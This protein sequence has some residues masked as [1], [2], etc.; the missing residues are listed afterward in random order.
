MIFKNLTMNDDPNWKINELKYS[1]DAM[2]DIV[3]NAY[4]GMVL[5]D[6]DARIL[7][8]CY[9]KL[10]GIKEEDA[11]GKHVD[12]VIENTRLHVVVK[13]GQ[14]ELC[15][16]QRIQG[17]DM[18]ANRIPIKQ[19]GEVI[20]AIGTVL[21]RNIDEIRSM[22]KRLEMLEKTVNKYKNEISKMYS[23]RYTF[24]SIIT[25]NKKM[26]ELKEIA[27]KAAGTDSTVLI[28]GDSGTGKEF[29]AHAIHN[30]SSRKYA[31]FVQI[32]CAAIPHELLESELFGYEGGAFTGAKKEGKIGKLEL[33]N[34]GTILL[35][36]VASMPYS[37]QAKLL[38][39]LEEREFERI[40]GNT[41]I[42]ID[43]R[44]IACTNEDLKMCVKQGRF[45]KDLFYRLNVVEIIIPPLRDRMDDIPV[46][47]DEILSQ[48]V[49]NMGFTHKTI[50]DRA[51][52][53]LKLHNWPGNVRELRNVLERAANMSSGN[54][55]TLED[56]PDYINKSL[57]DKDVKIDKAYLKN[58]VIDTELKAI[59]EALKLSN[60]N[61]T[62]A[63]K[64]LGIH[65]TALYKKL[66]KYGINIKEV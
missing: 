36:E 47:C 40:G 42:K 7:K 57:T 41:K 58:R 33:A 26:M 4:Q 8:W 16:I 13:T 37:M 63:A 25:Q 52:K 14:K 61:R 6:K 48:L 64:H 1:L 30:A 23:A 60:G 10:L 35:D 19:D 32:N 46:L 53:A 62:E 31:P 45:R 17:R 65:R 54:L 27:A 43:V 66:K 44:V 11:L 50:T 9:E 15:D 24:N 12:E 2:K 59:M 56:L 49:R 38:R 34:G 55:I 21:F 18:L 39:V 29:F 5:V 20:G 3:D 28:Q 22:A 51:M